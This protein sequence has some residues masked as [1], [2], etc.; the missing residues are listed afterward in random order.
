[1]ATAQLICAFV[2]AYAKCSFSHDAAHMCMVV[3]SVWAKGDPCLSPFSGDEKL[4]KAVIQRINRSPVGK[5]KTFQYKFM[6]M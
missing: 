3:F 5:A 4:Y 2:F 6:F 1:M